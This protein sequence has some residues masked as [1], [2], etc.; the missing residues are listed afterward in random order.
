MEIAPGRY[1]VVRST[2]WT[3]TATPPATATRAARRRARHFP[4]ILCEKRAESA[5]GGGGGGGGGESRN[6]FVLAL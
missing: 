1:Y 5:S 2:L 4:S 6:Y 3:K